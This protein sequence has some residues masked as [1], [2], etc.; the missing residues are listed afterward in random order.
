MVAKSGNF[1]AYDLVLRARPLLRQPT[2]AGLAE[3]RSMLRQALALDRDYAEAHAALGE[4]FH[5]ALS[6]GWAESP[7]DYWQRVTAHANDALLVDPRNVRARVLLGR[8]HMTYNRYIEAEIEMKRALEVNPNDS[9][10]LAG[11]GNV[12]LWMGRIKQ[13][14][15][16]LELAQRID[17][18]LNTY[19][20]FALGLAYYL[21]GRYAESIEQGEL[22]LRQS[23]EA[24]FNLAILAAS[25]AQ[26]GRKAEAAR[27]A[28]ELRR[29]DPTFNS[30][31]FGNKF[32][33]TRDLERLRKGFE[34]AGIYSR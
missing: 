27:V 20:R 31:L 2:R 11:H 21:D 24:T 9:D 28:D 7:Q 18:A 34:K 25:Y 5:G 26:N 23:P 1:E 12:L 15:E 19:D 14:I 8:M 6:M 30:L 3:A 4:T 32:Q 22:N 10:A 33:D 13:A 17:P 16:S 29:R